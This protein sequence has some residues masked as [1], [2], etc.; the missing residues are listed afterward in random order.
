[1]IRG[2]GSAKRRAGE[3]ERRTLTL[4][5]W[6]RLTFF[7]LM[8]STVLLGFPRRRSLLSRP[9]NRRG[10]DNL[11]LRCRSML[12][13]WRRR[14]DF[15]LRR[16]SL[17]SRPFSRRGV[18]NL[19]LRH[20]SMLDLRRRFDF[21]FRRRSL[22]SRPFSR[23]GTGNLGLRHRSMPDL[24]RRF[25][26]ALRRSRVYFGSRLRDDRRLIAGR[27]H[28]RGGRSR[29]FLVRRLVQC[30]GR[31][32]RLQG[33]GAALWDRR[34]RCFRLLFLSWRC[35]VVRSRRSRRCKL[36][37]L[38]IASRLWRRNRAGLVPL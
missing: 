38:Y 6:S 30:R 12:D 37:R 10:V 13:L 19:G 26:F 17:L 4:W 31:I 11:G 3:G 21:A 27:R 32:R 9:F 16:R 28:W 33:G 14:F 2:T 18:D 34:W 36:P 5:R 23:R 15:A 1:M 7:G 24:R 22:L 25:D 20:R 29:R 8:F 35:G